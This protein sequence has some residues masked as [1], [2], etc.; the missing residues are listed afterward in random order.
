MGR[1]TPRSRV[2]G[3][4]LLTTAVLAGCTLGIRSAI[5]SEFLREAEPIGTLTD[6]RTNPDR[7]EGKVIILG[8]VPLAEI[9]EGPRLWLK[10][11]NRPLDAEYQPYRPVLAA[12]AAFQRSSGHVAGFD[13]AQVSIE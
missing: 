5:P 8:G 12:C 1:T 11:K 13:H 3:T 6:L 4:I 10:L 9:Q 2:A 7:C